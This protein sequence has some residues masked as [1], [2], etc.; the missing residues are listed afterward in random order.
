MTGD[1][2]SIPEDRAAPRH[3]EINEPAAAT[4]RILFLCTGNSARSILAEALLNHAGEGRFIAASA[5]SQPLGRV[6]PH[7]LAVLKEMGL[8]T[9]GLRSKSWAEYERH[10]APS[11]DLVITLC[12][13]AAREA[14]PVWPG[15]PVR[16][17]WGLPDPASVQGYEE[18]LRAAFRQTR[19]EIL[20]RI[21]KLLALPIA[22]MEPKAI[23]EALNRIGQGQSVE[24]QS[25]E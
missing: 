20:A 3:A 19:D 24:C 17:H 10:D 14:C 5:G 6:N 18:E 9:Q 1:K 8:S 7:A 23:S 11:V 25:A 15:H 21:E 16:G 12:H 22:D 13:S 4:L 2:V